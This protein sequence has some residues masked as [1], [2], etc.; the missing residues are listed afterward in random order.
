MILVDTSVW[1]DVLKDKTGRIV[2]AFRDRT[3]DDIIVFCRLIQLELLEGAKNEFEWQRLDAYLSTQYY[4]EAVENTWSHAARLFFAL[5]KSGIPARNP[6]D[7]CIACI[8]MEA[9]ATLLH[10]DHDF[11]KIAGATRLLHE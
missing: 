5:R 6:I 8:A 3:G 2:S 9:Q 7:C 11:E 1:I 4:L 10:R